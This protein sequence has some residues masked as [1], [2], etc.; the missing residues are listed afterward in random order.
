MKVNAKWLA[1]G[2]FQASPT[3]F[4]FPHLRQ[5][6][7]VC[8]VMAA[9]PVLGTGVFGRDGFESLQAYQFEC[10]QVWL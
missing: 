2:A 6:Q 9:A 10:L 3:G 4:E 5:F 7:W 1:Q 8:G